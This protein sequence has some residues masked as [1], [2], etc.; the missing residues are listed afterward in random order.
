MTKIQD[1]TSTQRHS[2]L[3]LLADGA[4]FAW[5]WQKMTVGLSPVPI[6]YNMQDF[7]KIVVGIIILTV[8]LHIV[9]S[10]VFELVAKDDDAGRDERDIAIERRG[11]FWGYR[12]LQIG[13]GVV[14]VGMLMSG[15]IG[16][17]YQAPIQ[18][19]NPV[20]IIFGLIVTSY[21]ADLVKH[22]VMIHGYGR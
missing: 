6:D 16:E 9:I 1:M 7:G 8:A 12:I 22:A 4:V 20:Q 11:A 19:S 18:F 5:F 17:D 2:W 3:V 10:I 21:V 13:L 15:A 14:V